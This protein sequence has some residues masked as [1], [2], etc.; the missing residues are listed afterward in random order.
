MKVIGIEIKSMEAILVVLEKDED[1]VITQSNE[2]IK[3][4]I[5]DSAMVLK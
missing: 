1:G 3:I 2:S 5:T 4:G